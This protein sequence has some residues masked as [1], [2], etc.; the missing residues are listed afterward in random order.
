MAATG[1]QRQKLKNSELNELLTKTFNSDEKVINFIRTSLRSALDVYKYGG[2]V[3][4]TFTDQIFRLH[5][6]NRRIITIPIDLVPLFNNTE[7]IYNFLLDSKP[8]KT[9]KESDF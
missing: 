6:D 9:V 5:Y 2:H 8:V 4:Q 1:F 7:I 3:T